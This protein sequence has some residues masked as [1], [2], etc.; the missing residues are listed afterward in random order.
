MKFIKWAESASVNAISLS[1]ESR[2]LLNAGKRERAYYLSHMAS[3]EASKSMILKFMDLLSVPFSELPRVE[4]L[5]R[6]HQRKIDF[7][8]ELEKSDNSVLSEQ[9]EDVGHQLMHHVNNLKNNSMYVTHIK[10]K[11]VTPE[12]TVAA[13]DVEHFVRYGEAIAKYSKILLKSK[14]IGLV[15]SP[16]T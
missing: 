15:N 9:I 3:E 1:E 16:L 7:L 4:K 14:S 12:E 6:N 5:L 11:I 8:I 10:D 2:I 13:L